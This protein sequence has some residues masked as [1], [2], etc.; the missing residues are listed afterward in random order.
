MVKGEYKW[1]ISRY[2]GQVYIGKKEDTISDYA[3]LEVIL[4]L[5]WGMVHQFMG[6][7]DITQSSDKHNRILQRLVPN[8]YFKILKIQLLHI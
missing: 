6:E 1:P 3:I 5:L 7:W 2:G 4:G 8:A